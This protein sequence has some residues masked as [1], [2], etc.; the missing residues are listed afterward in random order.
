MPTVITSKSKLL[1]LALILFCALVIRLYHL[2]FP[3]I[4]YHN[5]KENEYISMA[6][7]M[8]EN[9]D[10]FSREVSFFNAFD[11]VRDY[12]LYPQIPY[13]AYQ[14]AM[15]FSLFG[16]DSLWFARLLNIISMLGAILALF[17]IIVRLTGR[18]IYGASAAFLLAVFPISI[19]FS[20]NL[21]PDTGAFCC[22]LLG[23][24]FWLKFI[25]GFG[26]R[27]LAAA[28]FFFALA[29]AFKLSFLIGLVP[30][31][32]MLPFK[33]Y[34]AG[35]G[36]KALA[37]DALIFVVPWIVFIAYSFFAGQL[38]FAPGEGR[39]RLLSIFTPQY[40]HAH[41]YFIFN[42]IFIES[43][44]PVFVLLGIAGI[45]AAWVQFVSDKSPIARFIRSWSI[46]II[47]Y[48]IVFSDY[49]NQHSYYQMPFMA[50][51]AA[52]IVYFLKEI[53]TLVPRHI[54]G[55]ENRFFLLVFILAC[56]VSIPG[57]VRSVVRQFSVVFPGQE[58]VGKELREVMAPDEKFFLFSF[59]QGHA[60]SVYAERGC[61]WPGSLEQFQK[62]ESEGVR[63]AVIFPFQRIRE[64]P[65]DIAG[66]INEN[67][68][69]SMLGF[70]QIGQHALI[71]IVVLKK[72]GRVDVAEFLK[73]NAEKVFFC[74][75][76]RME[77]MEV[78]YYMVME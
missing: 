54:K 31:A 7:N 42:F 57:V 48:A 44:G 74:R 26:R 75:N 22:M 16:N 5:M 4:G 41:T 76:Y 36:K 34:F 17:F 50:L 51:T 32:L 1:I 24:L 67:Y 30:M 37:L 62:L 11:G 65:P 35:K 15:G 10:F 6:K 9:R 63:F 69:V 43:Y 29:S 64:L 59:P 25:D 56:V 73:R 68:H 20:R 55:T 49:I 72:G 3:S 53:V 46:V 40:W 33:D 71:G 12:G 78:P 13:V 2:D 77:S 45:L 39:L 52:A 47:P 61:G 28:G 21:Q 70:S 60:A 18:F 8:L 58:L 19:F 66:Y 27:Q 23:T 14:V 38:Q